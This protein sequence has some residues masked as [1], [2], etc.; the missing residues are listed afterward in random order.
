LNICPGFLIKYTWESSRAIELDDKNKFTDDFR[1]KI[2]LA[3][4]VFK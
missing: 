2:N 4:D 1:E 3:F